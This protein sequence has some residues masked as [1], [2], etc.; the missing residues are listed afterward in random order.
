MADYITRDDLLRRAGAITEQASVIRRTA[1]KSAKGS[2]FLS[3]STADED[4]LPAVIQLL[5][6]HGASV[7]I[8]KKDD[9]L[10]PYTNHQTALALKERIQQSKKFIVL[11]SVKSKESRWVPWELGLAD[12]TLLP[13][14]IAVLPAVDSSNDYE[15]SEREYLGVYD[16]IRFGRLQGHEQPVHKVSNLEMKTA[17]ELASWLSK[18]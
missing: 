3:H 18:V 17:R 6:E 4:I 7:Y 10:P 16:R 2:V 14:N 1:S 8:D 5:E 15:W 13:K 9:S 11:T 12:G